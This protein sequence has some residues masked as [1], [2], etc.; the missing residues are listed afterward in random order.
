MRDLLPE[1]VADFVREKGLY[2]NFDQK[3]KDY[4]S[5]TL[6]AL[7]LLNE[8]GALDANAYDHSAEER[9]SEYTIVASGTSTRHVKSMVE[10]LVKD[11]KQTYQLYP[12]ATEGLQEGRWAVVDFGAVIIH[13]FYDFVREEYQVEDLWKTSP[14]LNP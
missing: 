11:I 1:K 4:K 7:S 5:F 3:V 9:P 13:L 10:Y 6:E 8:K 12:Q 2:K 14:K